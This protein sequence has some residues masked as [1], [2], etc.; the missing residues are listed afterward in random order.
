MLS[1]CVISTLVYSV[2]V[3]GIRMC[4]QEMYEAAKQYT[5]E[6]MKREAS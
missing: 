3:I 1:S 5:H 4:L 6:M 2:Y